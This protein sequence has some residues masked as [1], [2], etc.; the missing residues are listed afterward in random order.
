MEYLIATMQIANNL[1]STILFHSYKFVFLLYKVLFHELKCD[2]ET[3]G[4]KLYIKISLNFIESSEN[5][6]LNVVECGLG[7]KILL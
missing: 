4:T 6:S 5:I 1:N 7:L 3:N 2:V